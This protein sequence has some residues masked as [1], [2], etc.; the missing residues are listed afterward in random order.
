MAKDKGLLG[1]SVLIKD[2]LQSQMIMCEKRFDPRV[3][4]KGGNGLYMEG[5]EGEPDASNGGSIS[6]ADEYPSKCLIPNS[7]TDLKL[8]SIRV[9]NDNW[10]IFEFALPSE[11]CLNLPVLGHFMIKAPGK[12][13]DGG[14]AIR[15]YTSISPF[16]KRGSFEIMVKR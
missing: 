1:Q 2:S 12:G 14:D 8:V 4:Q 16:N 5:E 13:H 9:Y 11:S 6:K 3:L 10:S 7:W 15:Q